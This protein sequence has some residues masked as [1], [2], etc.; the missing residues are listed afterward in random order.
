MLGVL[1]KSVSNSSPGLTKNSILA[2]S[3]GVMF[4]ILLTEAS[5]VFSTAATSFKV[6][7]AST[8][9]RASLGI[10]SL[11]FLKSSLSSTLELSGCLLTVVLA[12]KTS[13]KVIHSILTSRCCS[14]FFSHSYSFFFRNIKIFH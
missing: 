2:A 8:A 5:S 1:S 13:P 14:Y 7:P 3:C 9:W 6:A 11:G 12:T 10:A 4:S